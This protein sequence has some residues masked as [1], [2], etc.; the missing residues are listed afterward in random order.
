[1]MHK[2]FLLLAAAVAASG[3]TLA[4]ALAQAPMGSVPAAA[5]PAPESLVPINMVVGEVRS[6]PVVGVTRVALG[7]GKVLTSTVL[8]G[9]VLL[10]AE[11]A[12][13]TSLFLWSR[14]GGVLRYHVHVSAVDTRDSVA[15]LT[16]VLTGIPGVK[17]QAIGDQVVLSGTASRVDLPRVQL[18]AGTFPRTL[19]LVREEDVSMKKM[20]YLKLQIMEFKKNALQNLGVDWTSSSPIAGPAAALT[21][22]AIGNNQF[23]FQPQTVDPT[24][25]VGQGAARPLSTAS[26]AARA[27]LGIATTMA[28][29]INLAVTNGDAWTLAAPEISTRSGGEAKFLAGGQ[30]PLPTVSAIGQ[31]N[32]TFKD[33]GIRLLIKPVADDHDNISATVQTEL[34]A[35]DP[36]ITVQGIPG[37]TTR[38]TDS[39]VNMKNGQTLVISG[40]LSETANNNINKLPFLGD[41]P[42]LGNLF[43]STN[44]QAGRTDLV[45]FVTPMV[46][47]PAAALNRQRLD[48]AKDLRDRFENFLGDRGIV[49]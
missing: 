32:V 30:V 35:I 36:S 13:N 19:N 26:Q 20:V 46:T 8:V 12:G 5:V 34:S 43:K 40:L 47:D 14:G 16:E 10:L 11:A 48:K 42:V 21:F 15:K 27:Y 9:E 39:E 4:P 45:I 49:D 2:R 18:A 28:S 17:V 31:S 7:N 41:L 22:D 23:R 24:F 44:F 1:M 38:V 25:T 6:I 3:F 29:R 37:F 33:F